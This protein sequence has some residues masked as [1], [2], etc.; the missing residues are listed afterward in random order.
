M[1]RCRPQVSWCK[2]EVVLESPKAVL[3]TAAGDRPPPPLIVAAVNLKTHITGTGT[4]SAIVAASVVH[5]NNVRIDG[6]TPKV[7]AWMSSIA[8]QMSCGC[9]RPWSAMLA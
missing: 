3:A 8:Q 4:S 5:L 7:L 1:C 6:P 2:L 9:P